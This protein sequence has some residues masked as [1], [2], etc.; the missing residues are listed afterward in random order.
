MLSEERDFTVKRIVFRRP[1]HPLLGACDKY[2]AHSRM[3]LEQTALTMDG[4]P[5]LSGK[6]TKANASGVQTALYT[7]CPRTTLES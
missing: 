1:P 2:A 6:A 7:W 4:L 3:V 5:Q